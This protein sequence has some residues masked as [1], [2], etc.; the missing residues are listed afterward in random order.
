MNLTDYCSEDALGLAGLIARKK[1]ARAE[2]VAAGKAALQAVNP[3]LNAVIEAYDAEL[4]RP[5][6]ARLGDGPFRGVPFLIKDVGQHFCGRRVEYGSRLCRGMTVAA[7][8][9]FGA[10]AVASGVLPIGVQLMA[11][12]AEEYV[13][14]ALGAELEPAMPWHDRRPPL[15]AATLA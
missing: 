9:F 8:D 7:D 2:V 3:T 5:D 14:I 12:P 4:D 15:H 10:Q 13:L 11:R 6:T 1:V